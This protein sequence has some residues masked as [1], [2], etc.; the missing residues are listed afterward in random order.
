MP[1]ELQMIVLTPPGLGDPSI[2]VAATRAGGVGVL[3]LEYVQD[4]EAALGGIREL[5]KYARNDAGIKLS[6]HD[7]DFLAEVL[8][9]LPPRLR[10]VILA[11]ASPSLPELPEL[12]H[13]LHG[14]NL[15]VVLEATRLDQALAGQS[16]G[17]DGI[18]AKGHESGGRIGEETCFILLQRFTTELSLPVWAQGGVSLH[19][20]AA[21]FASGAAGV[22]L[23]AQLALARESP[24]GEAVRA[25][26]ERMD[27][28]ETVS[29]GDGLGQAYRMYFRPGCAAV[30]ELRRAEAMLA[31]DDRPRSAI[32]ASWRETVV[33]RIGWDSPE[34]NVLLLGQDAAFAAP[35]AERFRTVGGV[36]EAIREAIQAHCGVASRLRPLAEG[37]ALADSHGT[38]Y[39]IVQGPM[40]RVSDTA[41]F[42]LKVSEGGALPFLALALM[43]EPEVRALLEET[44]TRLGALPWGV[45]ILGFVPPELRQEQMEVIRQYR[46]PFALIAGGRPDQAVALEQDGIPTYLHVPSPG[47]L[48]MFLQGGA[49]RF[50]FEGRECG[51]HV[52]PRSSFVLWDQ[53]IDVLLAS[54]DSDDHPEQYHILFA[55]GIHDALSASMVAV[56]AAP[57]AERGARVGVLLG[58]AYLFTEEAVACGAIQ[59]GFQEEAVRCERTVLLESGPGHATRCVDTPFATLFEQ[60]KRRLSRSG[61]PAEEI[62]LAL[63]T[64]N[65]GRL[66]IAS[67]GV[68]R[69]PGYT[70]DTGAPKFTTLS[71]GEQRVQGMYMIGQVAA[72]RKQTCTIEALHRDVAVQGS[73]RLESLREAEASSSPPARTERPS[74]IAIIGMACLLP[75]APDLQ[76]YWENILNRVNAVTE[77][78]PDRWDSNLY[79]D[80]DPKTRDK[81]YSRWGGFIQDT[82]FDPMQYGIPPNVLPSIEP[83]QLLT[84]DVVRAALKDAGYADRPFPRERTSVILG[85]GGGAADLGLS[86]SVRSF[87]PVLDSVPGLPFTSQDILSRVNFPEWTEDSFAGI[88]T[89]VLA[90]RVANRFD[91]GG[92]NYTVDA[93]CAS[94]LAA[95]SLA[96]KELENHGS[97]MV[98]VGG[99]DTMQSPF[100]YL[101]FSKT[102]ALS[103]RGRCRT[104]DETAD[105][106]AISE[107]IA[108]L[109]LKRLADAERDG[110]RIYAVIKG[111][112]SSSDG[113]DKGLTA[114]RPE[115]QARALSRAYSKANVSPASVGLIEA[116]GTGTVAGDQAE[117]QSLTRVFSEAQAERQSCAIGSV[118]SMIGHTKC[119]AGAAGLVKVALALHHKVLPPTLGVEKPNP[120]A[121]FPET[122]FYV[123]TEAR[124][125]MDGDADSPRRAAVSAFGFGG[126]N[127][128]V[129]VEEHRGDAS[130][131]TRTASRQW[132]SELFLWRGS[133][134]LEL[135][136]AIDP[137]EKMLARGGKPV[138]SELSYTLWKA[139]ADNSAE[140]PEKGAGLRLAVVAT[141]PEDLRQK[142]GWARESLSTSKNPGIHDPRG[143]YF[144]ERPLAR[145][146]KIAFLFPGQGSQYVNMMRELSLQFP[147]VR[148]CFERADQTLSRQLGGALSSFVYP[149]PTFT[150][151]E[152]QA[153]QRALTRTNVAQP[154]LGA[155]D[156]AMFRLLEVLGVR[157][158]FVAGHSYGELVALAA[159]GVFTEEALVQVSEARGRFIVEAAR[160]EPGVM[161]AVE[162]DQQTV[163]EVVSQIDGVNLANLNGPTQ[164]VI[165]G[166]RP[167]VS[168]AVERLAARGLRAQMLPVAC[169]FHSPIVA[170]AQKAL[171]EFL[172]GIE[173]AEPRLTVFSNATAAPYPT[174]PPAIAAQLVE[175]LV[176][177]VEFVREIE[178]LYAAGARIFLEVGPRNVLTSLADQILRNR[179]RLTIASDQNG[180]SGL[181]QLHHLLGQLAAHG[182]P[183]KLDAL[184]AG[185]SVRRLDLRNL[186]NE[187]RPPELTATTWMINGGRARPA[188]APLPA[189]PARTEAVVP[190]APP[191]R[192]APAPVPAPAPSAMNRAPASVPTMPVNAPP[193]AAIP[194]DAVAQVMAQ[195]QQMMTHFLDTQRSVM[196]AYL[197]GA[198]AEVA[199]DWTPPSVQTAWP[200]PVL[201]SMLSAPAP[202]PEDG[203][204]AIVVEEAP[205][206]VVPP[207]L[208]QH[209]AGLPDR[210]QLT[211]RLLAIVSERTGYPAEMLNLDQD[212]EADL[213]I[214]SIKRVEILGNFQQSFSSNGNNTGELMEK[215]ATVKTLG[216]II[217]WVTDRVVTPS[218][219][220][221]PEPQLPEQGWEV[222]LEELNAAESSD[223]DPSLEDGTVQ[224]YV[225]TTVETP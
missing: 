14:K 80:T 159:A 69:H 134:R 161:A 102:H 90:G 187:I 180:R 27:G 224:R 70:Q 93:A 86:Y 48:K 15:E 137:I 96:V 56:M 212:L 40:T 57:L 106:I 115:G 133:S 190:A 87:L 64:L 214:D 32:E 100:L 182:V 5:G 13:R 104:F 10:L 125:W 160:P 140:T 173:L 158:E 68:T 92:T 210:E 197:Q 66:R 217:E 186:E 193:L 29:L 222:P 166:T 152:D 203:H 7:P 42:A 24:L 177:P 50:V 156:M 211:S 199:A 62:R 225:L 175:H 88:L 146:G 75:Q 37:S 59:M 16:A 208:P 221:R 58:T 89:N 141:S 157:P 202:I 47:L 164:T 51:G 81:V 168:S 181:V 216:G 114:P 76:T 105:G 110:D 20:A 71:D 213:G 12:I 67:K 206:A 121:R 129:V 149:R 11:S 35:L 171:A 172:A 18:I 111:V 25:R 147:L 179:T 191:S 209:E 55:A 83:S 78:P 39:P 72:L 170:P 117:V 155:A 19:T 6:S 36:M 9:M 189:P 178:A 120:R 124:P 143:V 38:R 109:I 195:F 220:K 116:H 82:A 44:K 74:E 91:L 8:S 122:P 223:P 123:N 98:V 46:P 3:D 200:E 108:I 41:E 184:Y 127:F 148:N 215:L 174:S 185:R 142:L 154:A 119:T 196:T 52:G 34:R 163:T 77:V 126:T 131:S 192:R 176:R 22:V 162:A 31:E 53:M 165:S 205:P 1:R 61:L 101:C 219:P 112:G 150:P 28:S 33:Q 130:S 99:V 45:G 21:C 169:A 65:L 97:D 188:H 207:P 85:A 54:L 26:I 167:A 4:R 2:A 43:R 84:L 107:G 204:A 151:E 153:F 183:V 63:E 145:E 118:K 198:P 138:L 139:L 136:E 49:R 94:S 30:D 73:K 218:A 135:L 201:A 95:V 144:S 194:N 113:R 17:V 60:E 132:P 79:Y 23:D 103:P 128:H